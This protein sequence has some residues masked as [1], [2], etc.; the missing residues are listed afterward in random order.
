MHFNQTI[1]TDDSNN[2][3]RAPSTVVTQAKM[4]DESA[5]E[6]QLQ[7]TFYFQNNGS[8]GRSSLKSTTSGERTPKTARNDSDYRSR[9]K[10][11]AAF[12]KKL[13]QL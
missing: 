11:A 1:N 9:K 5:R 8:D 7:T 2:S 4:D 3:S 10:V 6:L 12:K 13:H